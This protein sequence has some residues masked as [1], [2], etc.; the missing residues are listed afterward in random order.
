MMPVASFR[1]AGT[2]TWEKQIE[3]AL[4]WLGLAIFMIVCGK[5]GGDMIVSWSGEG[6]LLSQ[7]YEKTQ[8]VSGICL[9]LNR[10]K[11]I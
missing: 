11:A 6:G 2:V 5:L 1:T 4:M 7:Q 10:L 3:L 9:V 8:L